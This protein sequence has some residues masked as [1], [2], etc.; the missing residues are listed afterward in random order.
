MGEA[1]TE[2][3][4]MEPT[5]Y[6]ERYVNETSRN[7]MRTRGF[8]PFYHFNSDT[9]HFELPSWKVPID[10]VIILTAFPSKETY[11]EY[12][13]EKEG[14][15]KFFLHPQ[16]LNRTD[17]SCAKDMSTCETLSPVIVSPTASMRTVIEQTGK[18]CI[19]LHSPIEV[20]L[21]YRGVGSTF[22]SHNMRVSKELQ[23][24]NLEG[25]GILPDVLG[26]S[27]PA[28]KGERRSWGYIIREMKVLPYQEGQER[29]R[30]IPGLALHGGYKYHP[31]KKPLLLTFIK[32]SRLSPK[33]FVLQKIMFPVLRYWIYFLLKFGYV[34]EP[35]G[36]NSL[37]EVDPYTYEIYRV[38]HR[39]LDPYVHLKTREKLGLSNENYQGQLTIGEPTEENPHGADVSLKF[40]I[41][42]GVYLESLAQVMKEHHGIDPQVLR[43]GCI[44]Y[45]EERLPNWNEFFSSNVYKHIPDPITKY[46]TVMDNS[47][48]KW[49]PS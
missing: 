38:I 4:I 24:I 46:R 33:D 29:R 39:D 15:V 21:Y 35:H 3:E 28:I 8:D 36:Q 22:I 10:K 32:H 6:Y 5:L 41:S 1:I 27:L 14:W 30:L 45:M 48:P 26:I 25:F 11:G 13:N 49:R 23:R 17:I 37:Y 44:A 42:L 16:F 19:K 7:P 2:S 34:F 12:V 20:G 47:I 43:N 40:D 18:D 31:E 9:P